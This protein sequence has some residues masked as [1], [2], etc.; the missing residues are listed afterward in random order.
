MQILQAIKVDGEGQSD[1][2]AIVKFYERL[3]QI[4][5]RKND[6]K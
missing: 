2:S 5:V 6:E 3:S 4:E 1:H